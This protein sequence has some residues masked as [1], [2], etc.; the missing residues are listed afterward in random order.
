[1]RKPRKLAT[2]FVIAIVLPIALILFLAYSVGESFA[3]WPWTMRSSC[4]SGT[5]F[6]FR[7]GA[8][9]SQVLRV[10]QQRLRADEFSSV[11]LARGRAGSHVSDVALLQS[12]DWFVGQHG[13]N[14]WLTLHFRGGR[15]DRVVAHRYRGPTE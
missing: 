3:N 4:A 5:C 13:C 11:E 8:E 12:S 14:C 6:G 10:V 9:Q 1:M 2:L 7:I 15:L